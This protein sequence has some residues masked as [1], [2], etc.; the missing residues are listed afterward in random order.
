MSAADTHPIKT[1]ISLRLLLQNNQRALVE[2]LSVNRHYRLRKQVLRIPVPFLLH[3][4][5]IDRIQRKIAVAVAC[6][7]LIPSGWSWLTFAEMAAYFSTSA[8]ES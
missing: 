6:A 5:V 1:K 3:A 4:Q 7:P 2:N 8:N